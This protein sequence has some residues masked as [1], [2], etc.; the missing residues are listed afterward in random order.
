MADLKGLMQTGSLQEYLEE[1]D[2]LSHKVTLTADYSLSYFL[3]GLKD[4]IRIPVCMFGPKN[5]QQAYALAR[6]QDSYL[7]ATKSSKTYSN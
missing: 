2:I 7:T 1:F 3:S 6:M 4:E 5:L